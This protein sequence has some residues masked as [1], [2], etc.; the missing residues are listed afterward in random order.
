M[1]QENVERLRGA[2]EAF[3]HGD[4]E[5]AIEL[6][7]PDF[8]WIPDERNIMGAAPGSGRE[9]FRRYLEEAFEMFDQWQMEP[10]EFFEQGDLVVVF[11]RVSARGSASGLELAV[12]NAH[13]WT[14]RDGKIVRGE[15]YAE[16]AKALEAVGLRE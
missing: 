7:G 12:R 10:E 5:R 6:Y 16:P 11:I 15:E 3:N 9:D 2:Y 4:I 1:S 8:E 13:V 14:F